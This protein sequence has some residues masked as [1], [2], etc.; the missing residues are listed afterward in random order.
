M[1][2]ASLVVAL[3]A[4]L[5]AA[6]GAV[7]AGPAGAS[8]VPS[9]L[10]EAESQAVA[11]IGAEHALA[12]FVPPPGSTPQAREPAGDGGQL[13]GPAGDG[14]QLAP[15]F[16]PP[17]NLLLYGWWLVPGTPGQ[18]I[19][20]VKQHPP[21]GSEEGFSVNVESGR[22]SPAIPTL[23]VAIGF[24]WPGV[25]RARGQISLEVRAVRL[26]N[27]TT[28]I[29][30]LAA[31]FWLTPRPA[32]EAIPAGARLLRITA[33][34]RIPENRPGQHPVTITN[35][36]RIERV[37]S[38]LNELPL[39]QSTGL[40]RSCPAGFGITLRLAFYTARH[41]QPV[42]VVRD[43]L[44]PCGD[45]QLGLNGHEQPTLEAQSELANQISEAI[46]VKLDLA[47]GRRRSRR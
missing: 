19:S 21:P 22:Q 44:G 1:K 34:S 5:L 16:Q 18:A 31:G 4:V 26:A 7:V 15:R 12:W 40:V 43:N 17:H 38:L 14:G 9:Q 3:I 23:P 46:G 28:G 41:G 33:I 35:R 10:S 8:G 39:V 45:V 47:P 27:G 11:R 6:G 42:A 32:S 25:P 29:R 13:A 30:A 2:G 20:Y 36:T 37:A 24:E